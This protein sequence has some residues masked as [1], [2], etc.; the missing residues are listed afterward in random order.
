MGEAFPLDTCWCG[1]TPHC[2]LGSAALTDEE[3][4]AYQWMAANDYASFG[5]VPIEALAGMEKLTDESLDSVF[6]SWKVELRDDGQGRD[7]AWAVPVVSKTLADLHQER[8]R[9]AAG[10][11]FSLQTTGLRPQT[12]PTATSL[13][14][15]SCGY[16]QARLSTSISN[17]YTYPD[18]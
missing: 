17:A 14:V 10:N 11:A 5:D 12:D 1:N 18:C 8:L 13:T 6:T 2:L 4:V 3:V 7:S 9:D 16:R 15:P